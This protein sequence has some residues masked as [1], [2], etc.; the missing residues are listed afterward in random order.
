M[1]ATLE[2]SQGRASSVFEIFPR[3]VSHLQSIEDEL[4]RIRSHELK[5]WKRNENVSVGVE[6]TADSHLV[7]SLQ[8]GGNPGIMQVC[9]FVD[10]VHEKRRAS[11]VLWRCRK[12]LVT[13]DEW[14]RNGV[15]CSEASTHSSSDRKSRFTMRLKFRTFSNSAEYRA[16]LLFVNASAGNTFYVSRFCLA[17]SSPLS[18]YHGYRC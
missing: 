15:P 17:P 16:G 13:D 1:V 11:M 18:Q 5:D 4:N 10:A 9:P 8:L 14:E 3:F 2:P 6:E 12:G 7:I